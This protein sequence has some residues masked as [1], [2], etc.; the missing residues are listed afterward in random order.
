[1]LHGAYLTPEAVLR[2]V[3][4]ALD[5]L[6][7]GQHR[8]HPRGV[9]GAASPLL[10]GRRFEATSFLCL[11]CTAVFLLIIIITITILLFHLPFWLVLWIPLVFLTVIVNLGD[12]KTFSVY[13]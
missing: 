11:F 9:H 7:V 5:G 10:F 3:G 1:M 2:V 13:S 8:G 4:V 6:L 12:D